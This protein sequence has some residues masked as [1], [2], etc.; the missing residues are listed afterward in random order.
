MTRAAVLAVLAVAVL[1]GPASAGGLK[2]VTG[3]PFQAHAPFVSGTR[4]LPAHAPF[5]T[6]VIPGGPA[7]PPAGSPP[8]RPVHPRHVFFPPVVVTQPIYVVNQTVE[9]TIVA[10]AP[11]VCENPGYW[12]YQWVPY[13][14]MENVWVEGSWAADGTWTDSRY[15]VRPYNSGYYQPHWVP[16]QQ[17][18][19]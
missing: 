12:A 3:P 7:K 6:A 16:G 17:Y 5:G 4:P 11:R 13:T 8:Q 15:E 14:T 2:A 10:V 9:Q 18:A 1:A 19:C